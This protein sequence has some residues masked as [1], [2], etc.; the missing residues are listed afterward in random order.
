MSDGD[1]PMAYDGTMAVGR[2]TLAVGS[3]TLTIG[4]DTSMIDS[5]VTPHV[6]N[7]HD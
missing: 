2:D 3:D 5:Y 1:T 4:N 7:P 6:S